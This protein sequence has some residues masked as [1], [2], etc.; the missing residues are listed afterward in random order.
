MLSSYG[1]WFCHKSYKLSLTSNGPAATLRFSPLVFSFQLISFPPIL[2]DSSPSPY[3]CLTFPTLP[4]HRRH[5][6]TFYSASPRCNSPPS[7]FL[8]LHRQCPD[9]A[10][11]SRHRPH[12]GRRC[13][14]LTSET[15]SY[16]C[17]LDPDVVFVM[18]SE[19]VVVIVVQVP[20]SLSLTS[21]RTTLTLPSFLY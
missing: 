9:R 18:N 8:L 13:C 5:R 11:S 3:S 14:H 21:S 1:W 2:P 10:R 20:L 12:P 17:W 7:H 15:T 6:P 19:C 4:C 16:P